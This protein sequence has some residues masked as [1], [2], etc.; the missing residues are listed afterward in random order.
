MLRTG[1]RMLR[2]RYDLVSLPHIYSLLL[3]LSC[4]QF[5]NDEFVENLDPSF[6]SSFPE[7]AYQDCLSPSG[8]VIKNQG[9]SQELPVR[10]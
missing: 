2:A 4:S 8:D 9:I 5:V 6:C 1:Q 3:T 7:Y 10:R